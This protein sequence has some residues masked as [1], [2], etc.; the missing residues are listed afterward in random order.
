MTG[1]SAI[2]QDDKVNL[3]LYE[4]LN[5]VE[6]LDDI[7]YSQ[8]GEITEDQEKSFDEIYKMLSEKTDSCVGYLQ[9]QEDIIIAA[10]GRKKELDQIIKTTENGIVRF[11]KYVIDCLNRTKSK[12]FSGKVYSIKEKKQ[13]PQVL[14][15]KDENK[16]PIYYIKVTQETKIDTASLKEDIKNGVVEVEGVYLED[17]KPSIN[18]GRV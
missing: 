10:K 6:I 14:V 17:G 11:K 16:V 18:I 5:E 1:V 7:I 12:K 2:K 8:G 3:S 4:I 15:I 9:K 13:Q